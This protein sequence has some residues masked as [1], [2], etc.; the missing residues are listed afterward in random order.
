MHEK[1]QIFKKRRFSYPDEVEG[2]IEGNWLQRTCFLM[3]LFHK[4]RPSSCPLKLIQPADILLN[5][6]KL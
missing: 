6:E 4:L 3:F 2:G 1:R 5:A